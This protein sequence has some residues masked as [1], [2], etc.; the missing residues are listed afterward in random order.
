MSGTDVATTGGGTLALRQDQVDWTPTQRAALA[1]IGV[2]DASPADLQVF[3]HYSQRTGLDP[4]SRQIYMIRRWTEGGHKQTIQTGIDGF[5]IIANRTGLYTGRVSTEWCGSDGVW[6]DVWLGGRD[7]PPRAAKV[8]VSRRDYA[9]PVAHVVMYDEYVG[10]NRQGTV[11]K[12]WTDKPAL[13]LA[14]CAEAGALRAAFPHDLAGLYTDEE[15][16]HLDNPA[17]GPTLPNTVDMPPAAGGLNWDA[18]IAER[19]A[20]VDTDPQAAA[21]ALKALLA[22]ARGMVPNDGATL[23]KI[24]TVWN[25]AKA[26]AAGAPAEPEPTTAM[27]A[28]EKAEPM[29]TTQQ[30]GRI[31]QAIG[32]AGI[33]D[34]PGLHV[35]AAR[36][37]EYGDDLLPSLDL[38]TRV[39]AARALKALEGWERES[40]QQL[41]DQ[42][43]KLI[44]VENDD[45]WARYA[46]LRKPKTEPEQ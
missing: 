34:K 40:A 36:L 27:A 42:V 38:L 1:Q 29:A 32:R 7:S 3:L 41:C 30:K 28:E 24:A 26:R 4:F 13:M 31:A 46:E 10:R 21:D 43:E 39:Q 44:P 35:A 14:K 15:M 2:E 6:R 33:A 25:A 23:N 16:E 18:L 9:Q 11:T 5:R 45:V 8:V 22:Q 17:Q 12:M 20:V 19:A 37:A